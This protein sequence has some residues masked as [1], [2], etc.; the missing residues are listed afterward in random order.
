MDEC[1]GE[2]DLMDW[3]PVV[4]LT[5]DG[6]ERSSEGSGHNSSSSRTK[7]PENKT[8]K[9]IAK[10]EKNRKRRERQR[11][12]KREPAQIQDGPMQDTMGDAVLANHTLR[13]SGRTL[14]SLR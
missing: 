3:P 1:H 13:L 2:R 11:A 6:H 12:K 10:Q 9:Q 4:S 7:K 14:F 8:E 5:Q